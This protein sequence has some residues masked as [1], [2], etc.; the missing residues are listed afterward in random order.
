MPAGCGPWW[1][2]GTRARWPPIDGVEVRGPCFVAVVSCSRG[3]Q[4]PVATARFA[5]Q[6]GRDPRGR[7]VASQA[8][9]V[10]AKL[11]AGKLGRPPGKADELRCRKELTRPPGEE[12]QQ[13]H[14]ATGKGQPLPRIAQHAAPNVEVESGQPPQAPLP[15]LEP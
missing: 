14:L 10:G 11:F 5:D 12:G 13:L 4:E 7:Q 15:E 3:E 2:S 1:P 9:D 6:P 8:D